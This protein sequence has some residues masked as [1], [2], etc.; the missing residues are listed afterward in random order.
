MTYKELIEVIKL[1]A[2]KNPDILNQEVTLFNGAIEEYHPASF[3]FLSN[4]KPYCK[5]FVI[6]YKSQFTMEA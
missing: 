5:H 1:H 3:T 6:E 4:E 2:K